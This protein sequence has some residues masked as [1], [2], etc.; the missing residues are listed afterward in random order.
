MEVEIAQS[1]EI[2]VN[3]YDIVDGELLS[4]NGNLLLMDESGTVTIPD[5]VTKI[6]EGA[7]A[8][9][10]GLKT[11]IIP[12]T[13]KKIGKNAFAFNTTLENVIMKEGVEEI[14]DSA[15]QACSNLKNVE[16][17]DSLTSISSYAFMDCKNIQ[18][19]EIP[20]NIKIVSAYSFYNCKNLNKVILS[21]KTEEILQSAFRGTSFQEIEI[22]ETVTYI[23]ENVFSNNKELNNIVIKGDCPYVYESGM[24]M[25]KEKDNILF[26]SDNYL[27]SIEEFAI[28]EGITNFGIEIGEYSN[29]TKIVIPSTLQSI[30]SAN[31]PITIND[32]EISGGNSKYA[33]SEEN[34]ILYTNDSKELVSCFSKEE[35][36]DLKNIE[37]I[38]KLSRYSFRQAQ[39]AKTIILPEKLTSINAFS[40]A[41]CEKIEEIRIGVN[42]SYIDP[43]FKYNNYNGKVIIDDGNNSYIIENNI[44]Y[45]KDKKRL[46]CI[47]YEIKGKFEIND[48][49]EIIGAQAFHNQTRMTEVVI[50][51]SVKEIGSAFNYCY[52]LKSIEIPKSVEKIDEGCFNQCNS[53]ERIIV[54]KSENDII[55]APWGAT[56]GMKVVEW[57]G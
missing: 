18:K 1:L 8:N 53:L 7:F 23:G 31:L 21:E 5:G 47:L 20:T 15:F 46:V 28:P 48:S 30:S 32:I 39:N 36:I 4:S 42:V 27:K 33:V 11:I 41:N 50:P 56:K 12:G 22:P 55:G 57:I 25:T 14:G 17:P 10:N 3:P 16:F 2:E 44:L 6:G 35:I 40:F 13:V 26:L 37:G 29:I 52:G 9:L 24:F 38:L 49:V 43:L 19:I 45:S 34:K 54:N 51:S